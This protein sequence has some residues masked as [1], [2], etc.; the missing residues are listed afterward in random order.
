MK[1]QNKELQNGFQIPELWMGTWQM[2]GMTTRDINNNDEQDIAAIRYAIDSGIS[3]IDSAEMYAWWYSETLL[4]KAIAWYDREKLFISSKVRGDNCSYAATKHACENSLKRCNIEYFD[5]YYIHW[6]EE[7]FDLKDTMK[8]LNE[9]VEEGKI[10]YI[11]VSNFSINSLKKA[12]CHSKY[13]I[14]A[15]QVHLNFIYRE[16]IASGLLQYCQENDILVVAWSPLQYWEFQ[17]EESME[18][19]GRLSQKYRKTPFQIALRWLLDMSNVTTLFK[20]SI[21]GNIEE[22]LW[23][24]WW[25]LEVE[26]HDF[27]TKQFPWQ[28]SISNAV[29]LA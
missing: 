11:W 17:S 16:P 15:N 8:A 5:L 29:P 21:P 25:N 23:A 12:Q 19:L 28:Q 2:G 6:R 14:V 13:P 10:R 26:D 1:I 4:G 18:I 20:S 22:N 3:A 9:L 27:L 24:L 7:S